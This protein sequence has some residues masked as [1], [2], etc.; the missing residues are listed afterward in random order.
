MMNNLGNLETESPKTKSKNIQ[1]Y[2]PPRKKSLHNFKKKNSKIYQPTENYFTYIIFR[3]E[4][5]NSNCLC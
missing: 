2:S 3:L 5:Q 1:L 4:S